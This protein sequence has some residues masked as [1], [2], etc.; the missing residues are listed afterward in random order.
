MTTFSYDQATDRLTF[1]PTSRLSFGRHTAEIKAT[2]QAN[3]STS[4]VWGFRIVR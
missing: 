3:Q 4:K 1:T 2:D